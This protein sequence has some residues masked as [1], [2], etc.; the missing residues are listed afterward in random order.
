MSL[1]K[2]FSRRSFL[3]TIS[4]GGAGLVAGTIVA[5]PSIAKTPSRVETRYAAQVDTGLAYFRFLAN[6]QLPLVQALVTAIGSGNLVSAKDAY[7]RSRPPYEQIEVLA[8]S[9]LDEDTNI[10]ARPPALELGETDP[11][12]RGF[13]KVETLI[14]RESDLV[15]ALPFANRLVQDIQSLIVALQQRQNFDA[16]KH[17]E[18]M[19][20]L[21]NEVASKK[22]TS[23]EETWSDQSILIFKENWKGVYSQ[24]QPFTPLIAAKNATLAAEVDGAYGAALATVAG[25][26]TLGNV[27]AQP[28]SSV[29]LVQRGN[30]VRASY[31]FRD[32]LI[33]AKDLLKL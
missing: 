9:F 2:S 16:R 12:F 28:Y 8:A 17:F 19:I 20:A 26:F 23:E 21:T 4:I 18:G 33:E 24:Y 30:I 32:A 1:K 10:D 11:E 15:A 6:A 7:V 22:I 29:S 27:A 25:F 13:H 31:R 3:Q 14:Y 5:Q